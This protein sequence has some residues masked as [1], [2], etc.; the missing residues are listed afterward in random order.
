MIPA[1]MGICAPVTTDRGVQGH[2]CYYTDMFAAMSAPYL[3]HFYA[4]PPLT[5]RSSIPF[6]GLLRVGHKGGVT[7][8]EAPRA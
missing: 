1:K 6:Y 4:P 3:R 8:V 2:P 5:H 7:G